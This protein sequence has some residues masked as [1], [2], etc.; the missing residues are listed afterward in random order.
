MVQAGAVGTG[1]HD[2]AALIDVLCCRLRAVRLR[3]V[4]RKRTG[5]GPG[6]NAKVSTGSILPDERV[7]VWRALALMGSPYDLATIIQRRWIHWVPRCWQLHLPP[8]IL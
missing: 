6:E 1:A 2:L 3:S 7:K 8:S 4:P 5:P